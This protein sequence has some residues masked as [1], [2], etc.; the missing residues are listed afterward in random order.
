MLQRDMPVRQ[1]VATIAEYM[2]DLFAQEILAGA[3]VEPIPRLPIPLAIGV[4]FLMEIHRVV[5][6]MARAYRN[7]GKSRTSSGSPPA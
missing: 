6:C 7:Q 5:G 3:R 2:Q 4:E 1:Q